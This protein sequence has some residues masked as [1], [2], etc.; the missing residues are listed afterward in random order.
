MDDWIT[1]DNVRK[2][3]EVNDPAGYTNGQLLPEKLGTF[4]KCKDI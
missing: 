2:F 4:L 1:K 3:L